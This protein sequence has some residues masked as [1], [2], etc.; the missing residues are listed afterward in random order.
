MM[1]IKRMPSCIAVVVAA[2]LLAVSCGN[3]LEAPKAE[4]VEGGMGRLS[5]SM[6]DGRAVFPEE[7]KFEADKELTF[8]LSGSL[9]GGEDKEIRSWKAEGDKTA[10][11][12]MVA[13]TSLT[14]EAGQWSFTLQ[15]KR[16]GTVVAT[17]SKDLEV[18]GGQE[19]RLSFG[20]MAYSD[21]GTGTVTVTISW[22]EVEQV[23]SVVAG[24]Y[25]ASDDTM[26]SG[27]E[28][29]FDTI[30][31]SKVTY[32]QNVPAGTYRLKAQMY[33]DDAVIGTYSELV[34]V[35]GGL[36]SEA[37]RE[38]GSLNTLYTVTFN[39]NG[40]TGTMDSQTFIS[41]VEQEL[42]ANAFERENYT[43]SG[44]SEDKAADAATYTDKAM[45]TAT[46]DTS[47]YA[48]WEANVTIAIEGSTATITIPDDAKDTRVQHAMNEFTAEGLT[49]IIVEGPLNETRQ[50]YIATALAGKTVTLY[51]THLAEDEL[52]EALAST[53]DGIT[54]NCGYY[55][56]DASTYVA[57]NADGLQAWS[58]YAQANPATNLSLAKDITL[59]LAEGETSNWTSVGTETTPYTGTV[60]GNGHSITG[61]TINQT[62][63][64]AGFIGYLGENG[65]V[66]NL[67]L[68]AVSV[69]TTGDHIG[70]LVG[71][72]Y[73]FSVIE[74]CAVEGGT[75]SSNEGGRVGGIVGYA[76]G[77]NLAPA[78]IVAC[79][80]T[81][82]VSGKINVGGIIGYTDEFSRVIACYNSGSITHAESRAC[83]GIV[84]ISAPVGIYLYCNYNTG[85]TTGETAIAG[86]NHYSGKHNYW[87]SSHDYANGT[88]YGGEYNNYSA[89]KITSASEWQTAMTTMNN[90]LAEN[91]YAY[92]Y[93]LNTDAATKEAQP[94][95]I[96]EAPATE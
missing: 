84:G 66:K 82:T 61:M 57:Y 45:F 28:V 78:L 43:F 50:G 34:R 30:E 1:N 60:N 81:A 33:Q 25:N 3:M 62:T 91:G 94:L 21:E 87:S 19:N 38:L 52:T 63:S 46:K 73:S 49:T 76:K 58:T 59:P 15:A 89:T 56:A 64:N 70:G 7:L 65:A 41:G 40:G 39:A 10:Y 55:M 20:T 5:V 47:L 92:R 9:S 67:K 68:K 86:N 37:E 26:V 14:V 79:H 90:W 2:L 16:G 71:Y 42:S 95:V 11:Q 8:T 83:G 44:W 80:N 74:N 27:T 35:A 4:G 24:L 32:K 75:I 6:G 69:T 85:N 12:V 53:A 54:V 22:N 29:T 51:L 88:S 23:T 17:A 48:V 13:D 72:G 18:K 93:V 77:E 31:E 36:S 96:V